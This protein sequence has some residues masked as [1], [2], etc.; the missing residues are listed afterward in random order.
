MFVRA[1]LVL[2]LALALVG[3]PREAREEIRLTEEERQL[4]HDPLPSEIGSTEERARRLLQ[5]LSD[6]VAR[7]E[8]RGLLRELVDLGQEGIPVL[9]ARLLEI[10]ESPDAR[11]GAYVADNIC[12]VFGQLGD[13]A[14]E[15]YLI[16]ALEHPVEFVRVKAIQSL[17]RVATERSVSAVVP[18][19]ASD[20]RV[21]R[22]FAVRTL[23]SLGT[24]RAQ[25]AILARIRELDPIVRADSIVRLAGLGNEGVRPL[26]RELLADERPHLR[27]SG[28]LA[29]LELGSDEALGRIEAALDQERSDVRLRA[30]EMIAMREEPEAG[31]ILRRV[32]EE[33]PGPQFRRVAAI[34]LR[35]SGTGSWEVFSRIREDPLAPLRT[36]ANRGLVALDRDRAVDLFLRDLDSDD[37]SRRRDAIRA[38]RYAGGEKAVAGLVAAYDRLEDPQEAKFVLT[39][40]HKL[41]DPAAVPLFLRVIE[42][43]ERVVDGDRT[44]AEVAVGYAP[45]FMEHVLPSVVEAHAKAEDREFRQRLV[46][47]VSRVAHREALPALGRLYIAEPDPGL[48][49]EIR[50]AARELRDNHAFLLRGST[51]TTPVGSDVERMRD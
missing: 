49:L 39:S 32:Y 21:I 25:E 47:V 29:M 18:L 26:A 10:L 27:L 44:L 43:D 8:F 19:L 15:P 23:L 37:A 46:D 42:K 34:G 12:E 11:S 13:P 7:D 17:F 1:G 51:P 4:F 16:R 31:E 33:D 38:L 9:G 2:G 24:P 6:G 48:R 45:M 14:A 20:H 36:E 35:E 22:D 28:A 50:Q 5:R 30:L 3:C 41:R 40:L